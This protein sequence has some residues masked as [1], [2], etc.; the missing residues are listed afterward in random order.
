MF[1]FGDFSWKFSKAN[2]RFDIS[3]F[4]IEY[5]QNFVKIRKLIRFG[6][7][8]PNLIFLKVDISWPKYQTLRIWALSL[9]NES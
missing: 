4:K 8:C 6:P 2:V 9:K 1:K 3:T 5:R 7:K